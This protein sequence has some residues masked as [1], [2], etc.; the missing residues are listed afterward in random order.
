MKRLLPIACLSA[1]AASSAALAQRVPAPTLPPGARGAPAVPGD[2]PDVAAGPATP[3][4]TPDTVEN[5]TPATPEEAAAAIARAK[6]FGDDAAKKIGVP[7]QTFETDHFLVFT[8]W[9]PREFDFLKMNLEGANRA[10]SRQFN[11][12]ENQNVF[13]GK[14]PVFMFTRQGDFQK[15]LAEATR[16]GDSST[17]LGLYAGRGDGSGFLTMWKP[18]VGEDSGGVR[19]G[20]DAK[21]LEIARRRW[22]RTLTH[23]FTH[24]FLARYKSNRPIPRWLNEG[25]AEMIADGIFPD[26]FRRR[27]AKTMAVGD[28]GVEKIF[29]DDYMPP[30]QYYPVMMTMAEGLVKQDRKR[31]VG[32]VD[33]IKGG[34]EPEEALRDA[35]GVGYDGLVKAWQH[36]VQRSP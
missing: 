11:I 14:L 1:L 24:A 15:F 28:Q 18:T 4:E 13:V 21:S 36:Y 26:P 29:D 35:Y 3:I 7:L 31:F 17:V 12:P 9:D 8:D 10:V 6:S 33:A 30:G 25:I 34:A 20:T 16:L 23:E 27:F 2:A 32:M 22:A 19:R 5:Y